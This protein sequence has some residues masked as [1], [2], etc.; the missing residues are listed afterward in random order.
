MNSVYLAEF[1]HEVRSGFRGPMFPVVGIGLALYVLIMLASS[2][3]MQ[4]MGA[5]GI[6]RNAAYLI[7]LLTTG[8]SLW[9]FFIWAWVFGRAALRDQ[10]VNLHENVFCAPVCITRLL[11]ARYLGASV[12]ALALGAIL[13]LSILFSPM[14][15]YLGFVTPDLV[16]P[17]PLLPMTWSLIVFILPSMFGMGA[18]LF[19]AALKTRSIAGPFAASAIMMLIWMVGI[20]ILSSS[21]M[22]DF[23]ATLFDPTAYAEAELQT[24][25]WTPAEKI[26][27]IMVL[28]PALIANRL[29]W[30]LLPVVIMV[31]ML[32]NIQRE[33]LVLERSRRKKK[34]SVKR[35]SSKV[36]IDKP[37]PSLGRP[38]WWRATLREAT[39]Q[40][41]MSFQNWGILL[42]L[43]LL[44]VTGVFGATLHMSQHGDGP[45][46]PRAEVLSPL[47]MQFFFVFVLFFV[48]GFV[49]ILARRDWQPG[50]DE[51]FDATVS[52]IGIRVI[53][54]IIA[55]VMLTLTFTLT[56]VLSAWTVMAIAAPSVNWLTPLLYKLLIFTPPMLEVCAITLLVHSLIRRA[57]TAHAVTIMFGF[58][59]I[60]NHESNLITYPPG[61]IVVPAH[62]SLSSLSGWQPWLAGVLT[63]DLLKLAMASIFVALAWLAWP[64]GKDLGFKQRLNIALPRLKEG[65]GLLASVGL[66]VFVGSAIVLHDRLVKHG[67]YVSKSDQKAADAAWEK[68]WWQ[69]GTA[70]AV[71]SGQVDMVIDPSVR[72]AQAT[73]SL[74]GVKAEEGK[75]TGSLPHGIKISEI[76]VDG[77]TAE[78]QIIE[79]Q[80]GIDLGSCP[81]IGC[82]LTLTLNAHFK[83]WPSDITPSW[84]HSSGVWLRAQDILPTFGLDPE[85][86]LKVA[87]DRAAFGLP[88]RPEVK[89]SRA[90]APISGVAP[91]GEWRW[92]VRF[93]Q[94]GVSI[95]QSGRLNGPLDFA[96]VWL[97]KAPLQTQS[98]SQILWHSQD[99][100]Q[101]ALDIAEDFQLTSQC[102]ANLLGEQSLVEHII[103][104]P[105]QLG[106]VEMHGSALW[107][108]EHLG[109]DARG[110]GFARYHR[111]ARIA[112]A[113]AHQQLGREANLRG[114]AG[115]QWLLTGVPGWVGLECVRQLDGQSAWVALQQWHSDQVIAAMG[116]LS[117]PVVAVSEAGKAS[118]IESYTTLV[119]VNLAAKLGPV[120]MAD[121]LKQITQILNQQIT[122]IDA[123]AKVMGS[124]TAAKLMGL[125]IA[126]DI[127]LVTIDNQ[128][129]IKGQ[130]WQWQAGGWQAI[131]APDV[132][133]KVSQAT[134]VT[135]PGQSVSLDSGTTL[136]TDSQFTVLDSWPTLERTPSNNLLRSE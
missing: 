86:P 83:D 97:P 132:V 33:S 11:I 26:N 54:R 41:R 71:E 66:I 22:S 52:P 40:C 19:A 84:L 27:G 135:A 87:A 65:A 111:R 43:A 91:V 35:T 23:V 134:P 94:Q 6:P 77:H 106:D 128:S 72:Q 62:I 109:W 103:Q 113:L 85:R 76:M 96:V 110:D 120:E 67:E 127:A 9:L 73:W 1:Q 48:A 47:L 59:A 93:E 21:G 122:M 30:C 112:T 81:T 34:Q 37:L 98:A 99:H 80:F 68:H 5:T 95:S 24:L 55:A 131:S 125:P 29:L 28:S 32:R 14:L 92:S 108:P 58:I 133:T 49:G 115:V 130:R 53:G 116:N 57:G 117:A 124:D 39:W 126:S 15:A 20:V 3:Q 51:M 10:S 16:G 100:Q 104:S 102:V 46:S 101:V 61:Q 69:K 36:I 8:M 4:N 129:Q 13:P 136:D 42:A 45:L 56:P 121:K 25:A 105:R 89:V 60:L 44:V 2:D 12:V 88:P 18:I 38:S 74:Q 114:E 82:D 90:L 70:F 64:R 31:W 17:T 123:L 78:V 63:L 118:W 79:D 119:T 7:Y 75:L 107:L 50:F